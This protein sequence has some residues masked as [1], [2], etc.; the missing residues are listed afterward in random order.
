MREVAE[1]YNHT[2]EKTGAAERSVSL[3]EGTLGFAIIPKLRRLICSRR[4]PKDGLTDKLR[5][6]LM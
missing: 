2:D 5:L 6:T 4:P 3:G 1:E